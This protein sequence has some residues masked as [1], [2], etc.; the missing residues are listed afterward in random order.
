MHINWA[1]SAPDASQLLLVCCHNAIIAGCHATRSTDSEHIRRYQEN[2]QSNSGHTENGR[3]ESGWR[4]PEPLLPCIGRWTQLFHSLWLVSH[5][6][7]HHHHHSSLAGR[8]TLLQLYWAT[9]PFRVFKNAMPYTYT[10]WGRANLNAN[11]IGCAEMKP[12]A[13]PKSIMLFARVHGTLVSSKCHFGH[14]SI[15]VRWSKAK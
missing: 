7:Q 3:D 8:S 1:D 15:Y 5:C 14:P 9:K 11:R 13:C 4:W 2:M 12:E 10:K 6:F